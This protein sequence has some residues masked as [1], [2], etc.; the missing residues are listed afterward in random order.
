MAD[1]YFGTQSNYEFDMIP[2]AK[3]S[4][5]VGSGQ[6]RPRS[7]FLAAEAEFAVDGDLVP[8]P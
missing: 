4:S 5:L 1:P 2:Q 7:E 8:R 3:R 6:G